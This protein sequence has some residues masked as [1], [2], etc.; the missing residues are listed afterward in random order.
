ML[1]WLPTEKLL[2]DDVGGLKDR[3][4]QEYKYTFYGYQCF[5]WISEYT[6]VTTREE[7][8]LIAA[9]FV[10][11]GWIA[12]ILDKSDRANSSKDE[13]VTFK[14]TRNT[15]YYVTER[16]QKALGWDELEQVA[17]D[18]ASV[19]SSKS[20]SSSYDKSELVQQQKA[21]AN[22]LLPTEEHINPGGLVSA[23]VTEQRQVLPHAED[24]QHKEHNA[25]LHFGFVAADGST[26][27]ETSHGDSPPSINA[28]DADL[29]DVTQKLLRMRASGSNNTTNNKR[30]NSATSS[31]VADE[32]PRERTASGSSTLDSDHSGRPSSI[33]EREGHPPM[34]IVGTISGDQHKDSQWRR[35]RQILED[36]L[37]RMYFRDFMKANFCEENINF[38]VDYYNL[39]KKSYNGRT[40]QNDLLS[41]A[42]AIYDNYLSANARSEVNIDH[43]LRQEIIRLVEATFSVVAGTATDLPFAANTA[44]Q[45]QTA[46]VVTGAGGPTLRSM[47]SLYD[48]VNDHIC[49]IMAQDTVPRFVKTQ[50]FKD[51]L[52]KNPAIRDSLEHQQVTPPSSSPS[53]SSSGVDD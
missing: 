24:T 11:Y 10:L 47:L 46:V 42:Y 41:D 27:Q 48:R 38:W 31:P 50:K 52:A 25:K 14:M 23:S 43:A 20:N 17:D 49:R 33:N 5:E 53:I 15:L 19:T 16:G 32:R 4:L 21:H 34:D 45:T 44:V 36:P 8:E 40:H 18:K 12:Q 1:A 51:L 9:E 7:A 2:A 3:A 22:R 35:L 29:D 39:R 13:S 28:G 6:T 26:P 30:R 37:V